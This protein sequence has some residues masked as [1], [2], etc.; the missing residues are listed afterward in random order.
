M[1]KKSR[2]ISIIIVALSVLTSSNLV[3]A[4]YRFALPQVRDSDL[5]QIKTAVNNGLDNQPVGST[6]SW[7]NPETGNY[8]KVTLAK[9]FTIDTIDCRRI[10][11]SFTASNKKHWLLDLDYCKN[12]NEQW[13]RQPG[14]LVTP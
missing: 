6:E 1:T 7:T 14:L 8:G 10:R 2:F 13:V 11:Y 3:Y 4:N 5:A 9:I 12:A